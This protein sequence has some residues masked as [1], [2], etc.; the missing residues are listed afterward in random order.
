MGGCEREG[1]ELRERERCGRDSVLVL[2][3]SIV[4]AVPLG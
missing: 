3:E 1:D 4:C 2:S